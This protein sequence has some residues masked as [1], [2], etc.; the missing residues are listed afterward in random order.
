MAYHF[1]DAVTGIGEVYG[2]ADVS[3][4]FDVE[5][6]TPLDA[7]GGLRFHVAR[8]LDI[9]LGG[10]AGLTRGQGSPDFRVF[11]GFTT[12]RPETKKR[13]ADLSQSRKTYAIEDLDRDGRPSPG[14]VVLYTITLVNSGDRPATNVVLKDPIPEHVTYV[15]GS[16]LINGRPASDPADND[17]GEVDAVPPTITARIAELPAG[18]GANNATV[19]FRVRIDPDITTITHVTNQATVSADQVPVTPLPPADITVL[20]AVRDSEHVIVTPEKIELTEEIHFEFDKAT[21]QRQSYPI[22]KELAGVLQNYPQL[23]IRIEGNTDSVGT[24]SYN[25]KLSEARSKSVR[26]FLIGAGID[27]SRLEV[28]GRGES[29]PIAPNDTAAGRAKNRRTEFI[30]LNP[31]ALGGKKLT[32]ARTESDVAPHSEPEWL[33]KGLKP[34]Q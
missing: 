8:N 22:L 5:R 15:P 21:I 19:S 33:K 32:P 20:P 1:S 24:E 17:D 31:E 18:A 27:K 16:I 26:D 7:I 4:P 6:K 28:L 10:G 13:G 30:V 14:D 2:A 29:S 11:V 23:R 34:P 3:N 12:P 25:Q 9:T